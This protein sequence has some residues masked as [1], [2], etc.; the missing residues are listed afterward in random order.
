MVLAT[1]QTLW[2]FIAVAGFLFTLKLNLEKLRELT[3]LIAAAAVVLLI[4]VLIP[5]IGNK[6]NGARRWINLG[7]INVQVSDFAKIAMVF[8][9]A[10]YLAL[11]Q[12]HINEF[13]RGFVFPGAIIG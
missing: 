5:G 2:L 9:M 6:V 4:L 13:W 8:V 10:H 1:K 3:P 11:Q 12:R 7:P